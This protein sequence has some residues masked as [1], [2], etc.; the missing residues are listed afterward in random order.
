[1]PNGGR[2]TLSAATQGEAGDH[3]AVVRVTDTG[4]GIPVEARPHVFDPFFTTKDVGQGSGLGLAMVYG[5][6]QQ[7]GGTIR[8][9]TALNQG[10]TFELMFPLSGPVAS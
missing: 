9:D 8:F 4:S 1:M 6:V 2:L 7:T 5:F 10:T 3:V